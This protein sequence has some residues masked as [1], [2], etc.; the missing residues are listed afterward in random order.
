[1]GELDGDGCAKWGMGGYVS[2]GG[3][4]RYL[5][6]RGWVCKI[7]DNWYGQ[8]G[9]IFAKWGIGLHSGGWTVTKL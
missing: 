5:Q 1:M 6:S 9:G 8:Y 3:M 4:E 2:M 7:E